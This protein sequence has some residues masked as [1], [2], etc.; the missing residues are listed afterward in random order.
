MSDTTLISWADATFNPWMG[1]QRVSP[2]CEHCYAETSTPVRVLR[3]RKLEVWG[4][5]STTP[6]Q[7]TSLSNWKKPRQWDRAAARAGK[8]VRVFCASLADVFEDH[9]ALPPW[10]A[11][12]FAMIEQTPHLD[13]MLLTKR[14]QNIRAM[15]PPSWLEAPRANVWLGTTV[16]DQRRAEERIPHLL[17]VPAAVRF[18]SCEPLLGPVDL[19]QW[20]PCEHCNVRKTGNARPGDCPECGGWGEYDGE[21][22]A[23]CAC[24]GNCVE[25]DGAEGPRVHWVIAGG[26]S[27]AGARPMHPDWARDLRDQCATA[28]VPFHFKQWGE[29]RDRR[30]GDPDTQPMVRLTDAGHNG[31]ILGSDGGNDVWMQRVGKDRAGHELDG[32]TWQGFPE[33]SRG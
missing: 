7:R 1:C 23:E 24:T 19:T 9:P 31:Q 26:E 28:H 17:A 2:A 22:C 30:P 25:C 6:R 21:D 20:L 5:P 27:G 8:R 13:W 11:E 29:W 15:V 10:R 32:W 16:E 33:V 18:L 4:P 12:L 3:E 14:P